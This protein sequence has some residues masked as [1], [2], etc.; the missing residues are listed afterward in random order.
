MLLFHGAVDR[1]TSQCHVH[2]F[3]ADPHVGH[4]TVVAAGTE[5]GPVAPRAVLLDLAARILS[6]VAIQAVAMRYASAYAEDVLVKLTPAKTWY[7]DGDDVRIWL[8]LHLMSDSD[9]AAPVVANDS[10]VIN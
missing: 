6:S 4:F 3:T 9:A 7:I 10:G 8:D 2:S 5:W 1:L